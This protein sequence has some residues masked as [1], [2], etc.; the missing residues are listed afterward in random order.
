M[1]YGVDYT[2]SGRQVQEAPAMPAIPLIVIEHGLAGGTPYSL[3]QWH[4]WQQDLASRSP[5]SKLVVAEYSS[6]E[7]E[8][9]QPDLVVAA[10]QEIVDQVR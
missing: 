2:E 8:S 6:H 1:S 4:A 10:V 9:D 5:H 3:A 7:I